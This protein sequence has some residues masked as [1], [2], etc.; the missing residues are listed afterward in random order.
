MNNQALS[1]LEAGFRPIVIGTS[2]RAGVFKVRRV[3]FW[4]GLLALLL[5]TGCKQETLFESNFEAT[6]VNQPPSATQKVGTATFAG[7]ASSVMVVAAPPDAS[8]PTKWVRISRATTAP[9]TE[10]APVTLFQGNMT[11]APGN[12][13]YTFST[14]M[15]MPTGNNNV[16]SIQFEALNQPLSNFTGF[17]HLDFLPTNRIRIDNDESTIFGTF[18]RNKPFMVQVTLDITDTSTKAH[19]VLAGAGTE[20]QADHDVIPALRPLAQQFGSVRL[21]MGFPWTGEFYA[22]NVLVTRNQ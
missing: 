4:A 14:L 8:P 10:P 9:G 5:T 3:L 21:W 16:A 19:I 22:A 11:K 13:K 2:H 6:T 12:G 7:G 20:G 17:L 1:S 15:F 18:P